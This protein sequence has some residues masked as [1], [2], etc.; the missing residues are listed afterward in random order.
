VQLISKV[1]KEVSNPKQVV[2]RGVNIETPAS[3]TRELVESERAVIKKVGSKG[4]FAASLLGF[5]G[6]ALGLMTM[7]TPPADPV[8][9]GAEVSVLFLVG[10]AMAEHSRKIRSA[11][12]W[13]LARDT[14]TQAT[15]VL[16]RLPSGER[17]IDFGLSYIP[18]SKAKLPRIDSIPDGAA[19]RVSYAGP[20]IGAKPKVVIIQIDPPS[21]AEPAVLPWVGAP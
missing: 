4:R 15:G 17:A 8:V 6:A 20:S 16:R 1:E 5:I 12:A 7:V 11:V 2:A 10:M 3:S 9:L 21:L 18:L 14:L 13:A 19:F